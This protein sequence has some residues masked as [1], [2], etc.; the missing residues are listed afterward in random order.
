MPALP[1]ATEAQLQFLNSKRVEFSN[2]QVERRLGTFWPVVYAEFFTQWPN[3][4]AE[5]A[6]AVEGL[7]SKAKKQK[8]SRGKTEAIVATEKEGEKTEAIAEPEKEG[9]KT[10]ANAEPEKEGKK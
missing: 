7:G 9:E 8:G 10:E 4:A 3:K 1:W 6:S 2:A 5:V